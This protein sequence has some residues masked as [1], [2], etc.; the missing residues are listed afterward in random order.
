MSRYIIQTGDGR[1]IGPLGGREIRARIAAGE[2]KE[3]DLLRPAEGGRWRPLSS[4]PG[5][6]EELRT[7]R[8]TP[9][10]DRSAP[11]A[12]AAPPAPAGGQAPLAPRRDDPDRLDLGLA[13][14]VLR[15]GFAIGRGVSVIVIVLAVL[16]MAGAA[17]AVAMNEL[18]TIPPM[19][20]PRA[21]TMPQVQGFVTLCNV[22]PVGPAA[23]GARPQA[24]R[25]AGAG[26]SIRSDPCV[27]WRSRVQH[28]CKAL[29]LR[30]T[31][32]DDLC[33]VVSGLSDADRDDFLAAFTRFA[34]AFAALTPRPDGCT[35]IDAA[36]WFIDDYLSQIRARD[37]ELAEAAADREAR[38]LAR[39]LRR[40]QAASAAGF[41]LA[42]LVSFLVLPLL[43]Q[44][45]RNTRAQR[46]QASS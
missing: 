16:T 44:I 33:S 6:A 22:P 24:G 42:A 15:V 40:T 13:D 12:P 38:R 20:P 14:R 9:P 1:E 19:P 11:A 36:R 4:V 8:D 17:V 7:V 30:P 21:I 27:A 31:E 39:E 45:E 41:A 5:L 29:N 37:Q 2:L 18:T 23:G 35:G 26:G 25:A 32:E 34:D 46:T 3:T 10:P 28:I 43:I